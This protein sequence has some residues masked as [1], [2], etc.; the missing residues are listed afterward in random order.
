MKNI[1]F[2]L[3]AIVLFSIN[4]NA[5][6]ESNQVEKTTFKEAELKTSINKD[7]ASYKFKSQVE[8]DEGTDKILAE[9]VNSNLTNRA[10][11]CTVTITMTVTVT[12][13]GSV[14]VAG[15]SVTV[16]V[17]GSVTASCDGA[18]QAGKDLRK[19]LLAMAQG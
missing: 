18:L 4:G 17:T 9:L 8:F 10:D 7:E 1:V 12:L 3:L 2:S 19:K 13:E 6:K 14:G 11:A 15:G 5:Q 16:T